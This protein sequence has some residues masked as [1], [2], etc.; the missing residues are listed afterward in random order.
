MIEERGKPIRG[1][2]RSNRCWGSI[3]Q[4]HSEET[5]MMCLRTVPWRAGETGHL[6]PDSSVT[7]GRLSREFTAGTIASTSRLLCTRRVRSRRPQRWTPCPWREG[8]DPALE[9]EAVI[10]RGNAH[11]RKTQRQAKVPTESS[12]HSNQRPNSLLWSSHCVCWFALY[13]SP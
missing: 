13:K 7:C 10:V 4:E 1:V 2:A 9:G 11:H 12:C 6:Y 8:R 3:P 5:S